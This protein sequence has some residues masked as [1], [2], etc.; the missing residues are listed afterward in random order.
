M[1][2]NLND[3]E[4]PCPAC[5][6]MN[7]TD[8]TQCDICGMELDT[9]D[10]NG[11]EPGAGELLSAKPPR[12]NLIRAR[13]GGVELRA[14]DGGEANVLTGHFSQFNTWY[15]IDSVYEG[16]FK[17]RVLPGAFADTIKADR[18]NMRVLF[19]HGFDPNIGGKPLGP[20]RALR[21]DEEGPYYE[22]PLLDTDYNRDFVSPAL[23]GRLMNGE[24]VGSQ[25]GASFRFSVQEDKWT[26]R[27]TATQ[28]NPDGLP[29]R[30]IVRAKVYEF[31][32]V[33]FPANAGATASSRSLSD[34]WRSRLVSDKRFLSEFTYGPQGSVDGYQGVGD[35]VA[36]RI[37]DS[38]PA[39]LR[40]A[41]EETKPDP[42]RIEQLRR[43]W[44]A[45][46]TLS[47]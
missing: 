36:R 1:A 39:E 25:L 46:L 21:E 29:E 32:P 2:A 37:L 43:Q 17:E 26:R 28:R 34:E 42:R 44:K 9:P 24:K 3:T 14:T 11:T 10:D 22:V 6:H 16:R 38:V 15:E 45:Q 18:S 8:A 4:Q 23:T 41:I 35:K 31:G 40:A 5:A 30:S 33:V 27:P 7:D 12:D 47:R 13:A 19:D 20:I